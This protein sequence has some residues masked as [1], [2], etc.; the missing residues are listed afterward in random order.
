MP[1]VPEPEP[2]LDRSKLWIDVSLLSVAVMWGIN[3]AVLKYGISRVDPYLFNAI[4]LS[5]S[6]AALWMCILIFEPAKAAE[7]KVAKDWRVIGWIVGFSILSGAVY[8][9]TFLLGIFRT[10]AGS[11]ALIMASCPM[12]TAIL[13][14][15]TTGDRLSRIAWSGL[16]ITLLGTIVVISQRDEFSVS[17]AT[18]VGNMI[19]LAAALLWAAASVA[20]KPMLNHLSAIRLAFYAMFLTLPIHWLLAVPSLHLFWDAMDPWTFAAIFYS[21]FFSTG[22][23]FAMWN[24]GIGKV[25]APHA[26]IY[27]NVI[28]LVAVIGAWL[29]I[30]EIPTAL[31]L[32]GGGL[33]IAGLLVMRQS[34]R[35]SGN[36]S[37]SK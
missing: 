12:W 27:Q 15:M 31:Q 8:Q 26:A 35:G 33:I 23:A 2:Q 24:D 22:V 17:G 36:T 10:S 11:T 4:R 13:A 9:I 28:P 19:V 14:V 1:F 21:G 5:I 6:A 3:A 18:F 16:S 30:G 34:R 25:G 7:P 37:A 32:C 29:M 20:S